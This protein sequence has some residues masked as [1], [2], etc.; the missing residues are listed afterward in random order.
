MPMPSLFS[1]RFPAL[2]ATAALGFFVQSCLAGP[3]PERPVKIVV[4]FPPGAAADTAMRVVARKLSEAWHQPVVIENRP[5]VP[6]IQAAASAKPDGY[7]LLL[8]AGSAMVTAPLTAG[9]LPYDPVKGFAPI[10]RLVVNVPVLMAHPSLGVRSVKE[11][12]TLAKNKPGVLDYISPSGTG[13]PSHLAM[14][15]FQGMTG[16]KLM[17]IPYKGGAASV[18]DLLAGHV[19]LSLSALP[20]VIQHIRSNE[21]QALAVASDKRSPA[22]P[23]VP[24]MAEAGVPG[25]RYDIWYALYAPAGTPADVVA[26]ASNTVQ[27]ALADPEVKRQILDQGAEPSPTSP[28]EL[29][30]YMA[31][32]R[33]RWA[34]II[35]DRKITVEQ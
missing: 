22:L 3:Y 13:S 7:T 34:A 29:A 12:I 23:N 31:E 2:L 18:N 17:Q 24:T 26:S 19:R 15:M 9:K 21:L 8:A 5:G 33:Q 27:Q 20:S 16:T 35:K 14:E 30:R 11:L 25:F 1:Y 32:E 4:Q 10:S 6:G 28:A